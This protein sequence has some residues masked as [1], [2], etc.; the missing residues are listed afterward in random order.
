[1]ETLLESHI[2]WCK[3]IFILVSHQSPQQKV[4]T[5][6]E[7]ILNRYADNNT[8]F[9]EIFLSFL[10]LLLLLLKTYRASKTDRSFGKSRSELTATAI[11]LEPCVVNGAVNQR[12][13]VG[14][15]HGRPFQEP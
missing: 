10:L 1:M 5:L 4:V 3:S 12:F 13:S 15:H 11:S 8:V 9:Q 6:L 2:P 7:Q 14:I